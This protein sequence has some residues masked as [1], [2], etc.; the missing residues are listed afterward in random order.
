MKYAFTAVLTFSLIACGEGRQQKVDLK[1]RQDS[2]SYSIGHNI[3]KNLRQQSL[4]LNAGLV[5]AGLRD[6]LADS[7]SRLSEAQVEAVVASFQQEMMAKQEASRKVVA[8]KNLADGKAFLEQNKKEKDVV[9]LPSGLQ[10]K[11][12]KQG[13]GKKPKGDQSVEVIY[14]GTFIDGT[15]FDNSEQR[16]GPATMSLN[17]I[18]KGWTEALLLMPVG[19]KWRL[20]IPPDLGFGD[21]GAGQVIP[22]NSTLIFDVELVSIK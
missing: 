10:Y 5:A 20:F 22:P 12:L 6:Y 11:V 17:G 3:G 21:Q 15:E 8:D 13:S 18:I 7:T 14:R 9:T 2:I 4:N 16:G 1:T 19:S